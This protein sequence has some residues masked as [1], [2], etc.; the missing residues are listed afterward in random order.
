VR[1]PDRCAAM[2]ASLFADVAVRGRG[3]RMLLVAGYERGRSRLYTVARHA[4][5]ANSKLR[6]ANTPF[7][8][9]P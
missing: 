2:T 6:I 5:A 9:L 3:H 1:A 4:I 7:N 8:Q